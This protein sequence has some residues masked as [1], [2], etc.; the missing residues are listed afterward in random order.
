MSVISSG[1]K[2]GAGGVRLRREEKGATRELHRVGTA[3]VRAEPIR[4]NEITRPVSWL[5]S[6]SAGA[7]PR[8]KGARWYTGGHRCRVPSTPEGSPYGSRGRAVRRPF[9]VEGS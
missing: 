4:S 9:R 6:E 8:T 7:H 1:G 3:V 2:K 5:E